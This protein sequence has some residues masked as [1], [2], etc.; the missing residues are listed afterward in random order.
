MLESAMLMARILPYARLDE[1]P[2]AQTRRSD[3]RTFLMFTLVVGSIVSVAS[4]AFACVVILGAFQHRFGS[5]MG[6][7]VLGLIL[8]SAGIVQ[9][10]IGVA[11]GGRDRQLSVLV[12]VVN[13]FPA[14]MLGLLVIIKR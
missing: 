10:A 9:G 13:L 4:L 14:V 11:Q 6:P 12:L 8:T 3:D 2:E 7:L 1:S 5:I